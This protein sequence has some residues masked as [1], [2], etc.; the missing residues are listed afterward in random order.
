MKAPRTVE[1]MLE[2]DAEALGD[3]FENAGLASNRLAI[4]RPRI[5][6][7]FICPPIPMA[8]FDWQATFDGYD[9]GDPIG[10]GPTRDRAVS[11][12]IEQAVERGLVSE[13][14]AGRMGVDELIPV[15]EAV[16]SDFATF[17]AATR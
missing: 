11:D 14:Q 10:Y 13:E 7:E 16:E 17:E 3:F 1:E 5:N 15:G 8:G 6:I 12:L 4:S 2:L 9:P